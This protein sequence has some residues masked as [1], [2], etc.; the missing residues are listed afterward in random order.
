MALD[1]K[2]TRLN[3]SHSQISYAVFCMIHQ[4]PQPTLF[5][6]TTLFRSGTI[7]VGV[8]PISARVTPDGSSVYVANHDSSNVSVIDRQTHTVVN[9][10][11][12][13]GSSPRTLDFTPDGTRSEEHTSE[14][15]SQSNLVCRLLHDPPSTATYTLSLHDAL[16][17]WNNP[18]GRHAYKRACHPRREQCLCGEPRLE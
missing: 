3:S 2:S 5:P 11:E 15:Q 8:M 9:T 10:V 12:L 1:R 4:A 17:I 13:P 16:P 14:L 18:G 7:P 6:Y